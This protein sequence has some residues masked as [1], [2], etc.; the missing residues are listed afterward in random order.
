MGI[1]GS[2]NSGVNTRRADLGLAQ[3]DLPPAKPVFGR[4]P[5]VE[6]AVTTI[7]GKFAL[8]LRLSGPPPKYLLVQ[9]SREGL[10]KGG[11]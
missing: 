2:P 3:F 10:V 11:P 4:N 6:L 9:G 7:G 5:M 8:E 1:E